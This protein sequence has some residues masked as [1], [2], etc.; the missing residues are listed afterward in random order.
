[1]DVQ[2]AKLRITGASRGYFP[3][4]MVLSG[5]RMRRTCSWLSIAVVP[6]LLCACSTN[7]AASG[8]GTAS[9]VGSASASTEPTEPTEPPEE[10]IPALIGTWDYQ[11]SDAE[12]RIILEDFSGLVDDAD[13]VVAR[14]AFANRNTW[15]LGFRFDGELF[16][17]DGVPEGDGGTYRVVGDR[18]ATTGAH[19]EA[20][21]TYKWSLKE[22]KLTLRAVEECD[23]LSDTDTACRSDRSA[24]DPLMLLVT[25]NT[26]T[27]S[28]DDVTY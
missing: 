1:M 11:F 28:G 5:A 20:L 17:L 24:M 12:A 16:L 10:H 27:R 7:E 3:S 4:L 26:F 6:V 22:G 15:W 25:E 21:I 23:V 9:P 13:S 18:L 14:L 19:G 2:D 8:A